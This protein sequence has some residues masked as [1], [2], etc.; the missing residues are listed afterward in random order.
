MTKTALE[1]VWHRR[2]TAKNID[3]HS[4][5]AR[6]WARARKRC[7]WSFYSSLGRAAPN[8]PRQNAAIEAPNAPF[9]GFVWAGEA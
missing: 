4:K 8:V 2:W 9:G 6:V 3:F 7:V 1:R 5:N